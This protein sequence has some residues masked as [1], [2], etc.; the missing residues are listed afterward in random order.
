[1][2]TSTLASLYESGLTLAEVSAT[3]GIPMSR[4]YRDLLKVGVKIRSQQHRKPAKL[5]FDQKW[6]PV[7][8]TGCWLWTGG[9]TAAGYGFFDFQDE[10]HA[11]R[12]SYAMHI[13]PVPEGLHVL[14]RCDVRQCV[15]PNHL[16]L[17]TQVDNM[18]D[19]AAKGRAQRYNATKTHCPKGHPYSGD[20]LRVRPDGG[21]TCRACMREVM[22]ARR[23][24]DPEKARARDRAFYWKKKGR[25]A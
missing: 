18:K 15:N 21:R 9:T 25:P 23:R 8:I 11:H 4:V 10:I 3:T 22:N 7:P 20:N 12:A 1:M 24:A 17:G 14:H 2:D 6:T 13:G 16:F 19:M 5:R